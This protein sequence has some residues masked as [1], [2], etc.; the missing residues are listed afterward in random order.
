MGS[1]TSKHAAM[2]FYRCMFRLQITIRRRARRHTILSRYQ[3]LRTRMQTRRTL[4]TQTLATATTWRATPSRQPHRT[5]KL[6]RPPNTTPP[7][8]HTNTPPTHQT[9]TPVSKTCSWARHWWRH[10]RKMWWRH[11]TITTRWWRHR[12]RRR[13]TRSINC[14][15][16]RVRILRRF[17][18]LKRC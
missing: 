2:I 3:H 7:R 10:T 12:W 15:R 14:I 18:E 17:N 8:T 13:R 1:K 6:P 9:C 4:T 16:C 5:A 11:E